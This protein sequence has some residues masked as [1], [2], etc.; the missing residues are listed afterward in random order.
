MEKAKG[1]PP[2]LVEGK[3]TAEHHTKGYASLA[4]MA[5]AMDDPRYEK[6]MAISARLA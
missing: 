4:E 2:E 6:D 3:P 5:A 1:T